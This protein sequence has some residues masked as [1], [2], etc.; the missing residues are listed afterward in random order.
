MLASTACAGSPFVEYEAE[1]QA[2]SGVVIPAARTF[3]TLA[4]EASGRQAVELSGSRQSIVFDLSA[5]ANALTIRYTLP[6]GQDGSRLSARALLS[7]NGRTIAQITLTSRYAFD[8]AA[9][10]PHPRRNAHHF[11]EERRVLL[12]QTLPRGTKLALSLA[13][14]SSAR[15]I[16]ID[17]LDAEQVAPAAP[18]P[19]EALS[20]SKFD[21]D[22]TGD[23][24]S[25]LA[26]AR[27]VAEAR[28]LGRLLYVPRGRYRV[29]G[30]V[31][32]DHVAIAG[33][34][35]WHSVVTG[36]HLGFYSA[37]PGSSRV[38]LSGFT[39]ESD[40]ADRRDTAPLAAIGGSFNLSSFEDLYL[41]HA[42][43]GIWLDGPAHDLVIRNVEIADQ[44]ADGISLHRGIRNALV[45]GN[46]IR[47]TGDD[48]IASW[49]ERIPNARIVIRANRIV[50]PGLA[51]GIAI[52]GGRDIEVA[53]ND[54]A[55][56]LVEGGGIHLGTRFRSAPFGGTILVANNRIVRSGTMDPNWHFGIGAIW[57]YALE[58]PIDAHIVLRE[59][60]IQD[61][62]CEAVQLIGPKRVDLV[63]IDGLHAIGAMTSLFALQT[64]GSMTV[65]RTTVDGASHQANVEVPSSFQ[66]V[67][68]S[69]KQHWTAT[70]VTHASPPRCK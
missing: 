70:K 25:T 35:S 40:V 1:N 8:T 23:K 33:A 12:P 49:S 10:H 41:H 51:N 47:N 28:R 15:R 16:T 58:R 9:L 20:L 22:S 5:P 54:I 55:D 19:P 29:D 34:G 6:Q 52:Y 13:N 21:A 42:K 64:A 2:T 4:A 32:V 7:A 60:V 48:G 36:H 27:A 68:R 56:V 26:F 46:R 57:L 67:S 24:D 59:N 3:G 37:A 38:S 45:E 69:G 65:D 30:H 17:V 39:I 63:T 61:A 14:A 43:V 53:D 31:I 44:T 66:L 62:G 11:W 50:S 18:P